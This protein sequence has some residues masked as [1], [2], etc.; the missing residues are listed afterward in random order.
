MLE[1]L[2]S[3]DPLD[4]G[5]E[6]EHLYVEGAFRRLGLQYTYLAVG[7][8]VIESSF[9]AVHLHHYPQSRVLDVYAPLRPV[10]EEGREELFHGL[11]AENGRSIPGALF[12]GL[13]VPRS[14]DHP[15]VC[16]CG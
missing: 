12:R 16:R 8:W 9:V 1:A 3:P 10:P 13:S 14:G 2:G 4:D 7:H 5:T 11:L 6:A 15:L